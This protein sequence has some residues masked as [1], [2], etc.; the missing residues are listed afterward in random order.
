[1]YELRSGALDWGIKTRSPAPTSTL[2]QEA[3]K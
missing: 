1:V 2:T 3:I